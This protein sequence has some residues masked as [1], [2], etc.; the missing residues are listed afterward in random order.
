MTFDWLRFRRRKG[1]RREKR[2]E[3]S[4]EDTNLLRRIAAGIALNKFPPR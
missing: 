4:E 3:A 2:G 1:R